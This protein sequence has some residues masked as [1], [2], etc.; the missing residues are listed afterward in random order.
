MGTARAVRAALWLPP[1]RLLSS[2]RRGMLRLCRRFGVG[3]GPETQPSPSLDLS[4]TYI[5]LVFDG[6]EARLLADVDAPLDHGR[7]RRRAARLAVA[8]AWRAVA[9]LCTLPPENFAK[10]RTIRRPSEA[11]HASQCTA[12]PTCFWG[13]LLLR[14]RSITR[15]GRSRPESADADLPAVRESKAGEVPGPPPPREVDIRFT[16]AWDT[17]GRRTPPVSQSG[18]VGQCHVRFAVI[19]GRAIGTYAVADPARQTGLR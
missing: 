18:D 12:V 19:T 1:D 2:L 16:A 15:H 9:C 4:R 5:D 13:H 10:G 11:F 7:L 8:T 6:T 17:R 14:P 3:F